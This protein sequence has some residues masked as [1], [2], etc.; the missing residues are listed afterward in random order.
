M[1]NTIICS[2]CSTP[3]PP[4]EYICRKCNSFIRSRVYNIDLWKT[5]GLLVEKPKQAFE[6]IVYSEHKNFITFILLFVTSKLFVDIRFISMVTVGQ[7]SATTNLFIIYLIVF[8]TITTYLLLFSFVLKLVLRTSEIET[9]FR[10]NLA[11]LIYAFIPHIFGLIFLFVLEL[12]VFGDYL[13]SVNPTPFV[14]KGLIAYL[15]L[16]A[17]VLLILW[18][19][20][21]TYSALR[22]QSGSIY[23]GILSTL[24]F[25]LLLAGILYFSSLVIFR[26]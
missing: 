1:K 4:F 11:V 10:D 5:L 8:G 19:V 23:L 6:E 7:Y 14:I 21:L 17:E 25:Y 26:L 2:S 13:F 9:R 12:V 16:G 18:S 24:I 20:F 15:F 3:N 22:V